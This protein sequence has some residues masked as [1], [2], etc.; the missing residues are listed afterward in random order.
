ML[1]RGGRSP[2][3]VSQNG[4]QGLSWTLY[5]DVKYVLLVG[6][7]CTEK[8]TSASCCPVFFSVGRHEPCNR[9]HGTVGINMGN[10]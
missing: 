10:G 1:G 5:R 4:R 6:K 3:M 9:Q 8:C 2:S 7:K